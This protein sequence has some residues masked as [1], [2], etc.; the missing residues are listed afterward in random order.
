MR[1]PTTDEMDGL[2]TEEDIKNRHTVV[3]QCKLC[4]KWTKH[5]NHIPGERNEHVPC[6][7]CGEIHYDESSIKS[8][9]T[10]NPLTDNKRK[11]K[12]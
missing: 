10:Y 4:R 2:L 1:I 7:D 12:K 11:I 3:Y 9:R 8:W 6:E 5:E